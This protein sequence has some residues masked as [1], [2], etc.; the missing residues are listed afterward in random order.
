MNL[1]MTLEENLHAMKIFFSRQFC[2]QK[3]VRVQR[4]NKT[5]FGRQNASEKHHEK[6]AR[7]AILP[8]RKS[9]QVLRDA[10]PLQTA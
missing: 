4:C 3:K 7:V 8:S 2:G 5:N 1:R 6:T 10:A 9:K